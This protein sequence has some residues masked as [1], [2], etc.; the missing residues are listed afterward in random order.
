MD[1]ELPNLELTCHINSDS[2]CV[3]EQGELLMELKR[4]RDESVAII[5]AKKVKM[6]SNALSTGADA[7]SE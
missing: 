2:V 4:K 6:L 3:L 7:G 5:A 1:W